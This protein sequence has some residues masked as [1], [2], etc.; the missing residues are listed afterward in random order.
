M[1]IAL[2]CNDGSPLGV[3]LKD[4]W[5]KGR[6][7][8]GIGGSEY[9]LLTMCEQW[10]NDGHEVILYNDPLDKSDNLFDQRAISSFDTRDDPDVLITFRSPNPRAI[11]SKAKL[12]VWWSCDQFTLPHLRF[13]DFA[14][15]MDKIVL[16]SEYHKNYFADTYNIH[17][18]VVID[19]PVR[20][21]D[22]DLVKDVKKVKNRMIFTSVPDRGLQYLW[23]MWPRIKR[24]IPDAELCITSDY[25]LWNCSNPQNQQHRL[26]WMHYEGIRF[27]GAIPREQLL[28]EQAEAE[29][30]LYPSY[31][32]TA[33]LFCVSVAEAQAMGAFPITSSWGALETTNMGSIIPGRADRTD[34]H[35]RF[36]DEVKRL[37]EDAWELVDETNRIQTRAKQRF[38]PSI[39]SKQWSE[40]VFR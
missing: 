12:K 7:G 35:Q 4:L 21:Q 23:Y 29:F 11:A 31:Y 19:L 5:G 16:I 40:K 15:H 20:F 10:H 14:S 30:L 2:L 25:R 26:Q 38:H 24:D 8:I 39:I 36:I 37:S 3:S 9:A 27:L 1:K 13:Q 32:D 34:F 33:E 22:F 17:D 28:K 6:R 18:T